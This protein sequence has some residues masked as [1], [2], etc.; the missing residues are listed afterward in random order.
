MEESVN[1]I[2]ICALVLLF[3]LIPGFE[4]VMRSWS[5]FCSRSPLDTGMKLTKRIPRVRR[6]AKKVQ[7]F[8]LMY[9]ISWN[10]KEAKRKFAFV[11]SVVTIWIMFVAWEAF[12][13]VF[14]AVRCLIK[15]CEFTIK[16]WV[17]KACCR[18]MEWLQWSVIEEKGVL[19]REFSHLLWQER[20]L[21]RYFTLIENRI[22]KWLLCGRHAPKWNSRAFRS[23][24]IF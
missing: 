23:S 21:M 22:L 19:L 24:R 1:D 10:T 18:L 11:S 8:V 17:K 7:L 4:P 2:R 16:N 5:N 6:M 3:L 15:I 13:I 20:I 14:G 9:L 12:G